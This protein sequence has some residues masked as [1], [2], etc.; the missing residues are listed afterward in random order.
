M[1]KKYLRHSIVMILLFLVGGFSIL[2]FLFELYS[3]FW[4]EETLGMQNIQIQNIS[5][6]SNRILPPNNT[7]RFFQGEHGMQRLSPE[8]I[9]TSPFS[10][11]L[12][13]AGVL[14]VLGGISVFQLTREKELKS[15][16]EDV[17]ALLMTPEERAIVDELKKANGK[18]N[19]NQLVKK[20]GF[21]K[22]R[23]HRAIVRLETRKIVKKYPY[24]L[25]NKIVLEKTAL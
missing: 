14:S 21:S 11:V 5:N 2:L 20:T 15:I 10:M 23:I 16:K 6:D 9:L 19:Q 13:F 17:T 7:N 8:T 24:G 4:G 18:M 3:A 12:L 22:V 25:T 1:D